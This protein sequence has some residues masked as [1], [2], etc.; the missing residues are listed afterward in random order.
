VQPNSPRSR[1]VN[2][3]CLTLTKM[4]GD[5]IETVEKHYTPFVREL[6]ERVRT[7]LDSEGGFESPQADRVNTVKT[8]SKSS[9][10]LM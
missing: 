9:I 1:C 5:A 4:L 3:P 8:V 7:I 2:A 6:R 10:N